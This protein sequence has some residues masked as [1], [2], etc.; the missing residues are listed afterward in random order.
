MAPRA[1]EIYPRLLGPAWT[2][3]PELVRRC[4]SANPTLVARGLFAVAHARSPIA[5]FVIRL[6]GMPPAGDRVETR[7]S[8][9]AFPD[10]QRWER[11]FAGHVLTTLQYCLDDGRLAERSGAFE[12]LF[13]VEAEDGV[14]HYRPAGVRLCFGRFRV[15]L[16]SWC[17]PRV[18]ARAWSEPGAVAMN[19]RIEIAA[20][21]LGTLVTYGGPLRPMQG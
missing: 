4:H 9:H 17:A 18:K 13:R 2:D 3:L 11:D 20:P 21:L 5:R 10:H 12:L 8:V 6:A 14:V 19:V 15:P 7:L 16:P 1:L